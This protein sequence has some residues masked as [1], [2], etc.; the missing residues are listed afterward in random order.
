LSELR[1]INILKF[2]STPHL[3]ATLVIKRKI[4]RRHIEECLKVL[5]GSSLERLF[6]LNI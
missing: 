2:K 5:N 1:I 3:L 6:Y 4:S